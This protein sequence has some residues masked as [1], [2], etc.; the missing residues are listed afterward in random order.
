MLKFAD[1]RVDVKSF[2]N[3][4]SSFLKLFPNSYIPLLIMYLS[5]EG[6]LEVKSDVGEDNDPAV[7]L[8]ISK[9]ELVEFINIESLNVS[10]VKTMADLFKSFLGIKSEVCSEDLLREYDLSSIYAFSDLIKEIT[11][12]AKTYSLVYNSKGNDNID[13]IKAILL[14]HNPLNKEKAALWFFCKIFLYSTP[15]VEQYD[16]THDFRA[17]L[18]NFE[19]TLER[20][21]AYSGRQEFL[22]PWALTRIILSQY[23]GGSVYNPFAGV[24][25]Y[26]TAMCYESQFYQFDEP[27]EE[28]W[29][30]LGD[31]YYGEEINELT[32]AIGKLRLMFYHMDSANYILGDSTKEFEGRIDNILCTPPFNHQII[33]ES[34][35]KEFADHFVFRRGIDMLADEGMMAVVVPVSFLSRRDT[36]DIR[37]DLVSKHLLTHVVYLPENI[38][39]STRVSTAI[40]F[41]HK[42]TK[43][44]N[45]KLV[46]ATSRRANIYGLNISA[47]SNLIEHDSY[48]N[49]EDDFTFGE[50][51]YCNELT[52]SVFNTCISFEDYGNVAANDYDLSPSYYFSSYIDVPE[53]YKLVSL[54]ELLY[55]K[56]PANISG[57]VEGKV[58]SNSNLANDYQMPYVDVDSLV[59]KVINSNYK[60]LERKSL[61][62][63]SMNEL[64]PSIFVSSDV[65]VY[66]SP[67]V[68]AFY[69]NDKKVNAEYLVGELSKDYVKEQLRLMIMGSTIQRI[70]RDDILWLNILVPDSKNFLKKEKEIANERKDNYLE[71]M[72]VELSELR[73][74]RHDEY[75]KMLR[76]RKHRI[77]QVMNEFSPAFSLLDKCREENGGTLH[78]DDI[79]AARTGDTVSDYFNKLHHIVTKVEDLVT[80]L[81]DKDHWEPSTMVNVDRFVDSIPQL[82]LSDKYDI[83]TLHDHDVY[84]EEEGETVDLNEDR[85]INI[86]ED[87]L[88]I[89]FDNIIANASKWGFVD[90]IRRDYR[91]RIDVSDASINGKSAVRICISNNG[92]P[93]HLSV[94][95]KRFFEWG[96]GSGT[97][98]GTW[99]LKDIVDH[100]GG[101]IKLNEYPDEISG[102]QTEYEIILPLAF[103]D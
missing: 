71:K 33:N 25:S 92:N 42:N 14:S 94:D 57:E 58:I 98:I 18:S 78:N 28:G 24:A 70:K 91:I 96:Y 66:V 13:K 46:D 52:P 65:D 9:D 47:I 10:N 40:L 81:V 22:Q 72:G 43:R 60:L 67:N 49:H 27:E 31:S 17:A 73:D 41:V 7:L 32:W 55:S 35:N 5:K 54:K 62:V 6:L 39:S 51:G 93:I 61:L 86:N 64:K 88:A 84:I 15:R 89:L 77:Q 87:D 1:L 100:Y 8:S 95:R 4:L 48:P 20:I 97:G 16:S 102:F 19:M 21:S 99:Q 75:V 11:N 74:K 45:L 50:S 12:D 90:P 38:F 79:V 37:K 59:S 63:S 3:T 56:K 82:H 30:S 26:H 83:Q 36:F 103:D 76:Q 29:N 34:G 80:N 69:L 68:L 44:K 85:F 101:T 53:G 2:E 23:K